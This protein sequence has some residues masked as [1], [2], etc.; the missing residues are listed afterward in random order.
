MSSTAAGGDRRSA[1]DTGEA[2]GYDSKKHRDQWR[3]QG[4]ELCIPA[5]SNIK[6]PEL[7]D[8]ALY[9]TRHCVENKFQSLKVFRRVARRYGKTKRMSYMSIIISISV[10]YER[11]SL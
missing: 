11:D 10:T 9:G 6:N 4:C 2:V 1:A 8:E 3:C 7:Y 5:R